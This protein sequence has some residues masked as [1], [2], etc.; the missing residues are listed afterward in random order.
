[1]ARSLLEKCKV[2]L[3]DEATSSV[4][5]DTD[6]LI[7]MTIRSPQAFGGCTVLTIA[8]RINTVIDSHRIL[9]LDQGTVAEYDSPE[10]LLANPK[11]N[12]SAMVHETKH[13]SGRAETK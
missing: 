11:S 1:M 8:H 6:A 3:L 5:Y 10:V 13:T 2:L 7:Q 12:L 9:V 4:D